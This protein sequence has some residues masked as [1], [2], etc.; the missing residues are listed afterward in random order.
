MQY[1]DTITISNHLESDKFAMLLIVLL[2]SLVVYCAVNIL[3]DHL[4]MK[5][6]ELAI[7]LIEKGHNAKQAGLSKATSKNNKIKKTKSGD[8]VNDNRISERG[9]RRSYYSSV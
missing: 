6:I 5:K 9:K 3:C 4:R 1:T 7:Y 2:I 8:V